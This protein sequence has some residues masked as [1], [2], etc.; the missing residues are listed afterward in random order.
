V[1]AL[2][3]FL[4]TPVAA[5]EPAP[6]VKVELSPKDGAWV[7][8]R[9]TL[10]ITLY[11]PDLF[12]GVPSFDLP[13]VPGVVVLPPSGSP[14]IGSEKIGDDSFTTQ[15][16]EYAIYTQRAGEVR[17]P[18]FRIRFESNAGF[19]MPTVLREVTTTALS[20]T[21]K[22]PPGAEK[23]GTVIAA[24]N[25]TVT[26]EWKPQPK[27]PKVGDAFTRTLT[28]SADGVP[29]MAFPSF[30]LEEIAGLSAYPKEPTV[31]DRAER[32]A[33]TGQ[34]IETVTY[35][36]NESGTV[37]VPDRMLT[38]YDLG[39]KGLKTVNLPGRTFT[40]A[41]NPSPE[42]STSA[43]P[44][45]P[46]TDHRWW[47]AVAVVIAAVGWMLVI[48]VWP[49]WVRYRTARVES[50]ASY[51][52]RLRRACRCDEP[53]GVY[54][55]LLAWLDRFGPMTL[56]AFT[57]RAGD[58][59]LTRAVAGL[60]ER[61]YARPCSGGTGVW[62]ASHLLARVEAVRRNWQSSR[63]GSVSK[64]LPPLNPNDSLA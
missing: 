61:V 48:W 3:L 2:F 24:R 37:T 26:D 31:N 34:R 53:H 14:V 59:E 43:R 62:S 55:S 42:Q 41:P 58:P 12:A 7:G 1:V 28:V 21:A 63:T 52:T 39:E 15:R 38:W 11:T 40:V 57:T 64:S 36:C 16:H 44:L 30:R 5:A 4:I 17:I 60:E 51:F 35:V 47:V 20:F 29:G 50:E 10:A 22:T 6:R 19:G 27:A 46:E 23:L 45:A 18:A 8:Q 32:G 33:L 54:V 25:L 13:Q 49:W 56:N 9:V